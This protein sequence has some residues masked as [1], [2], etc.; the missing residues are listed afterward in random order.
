MIHKNLTPGYDVHNLGSRTTRRS[1]QPMWVHRPIKLLRHMSPRR[2]AKG[3]MG[4]LGLNNARATDSWV[5]L[6]PDP[7]DIT[8]AAV[9]LW[10]FSV[11]RPRSLRTIPCAKL[12]FCLG[13]LPQDL[14]QTSAR[15]CTTWPA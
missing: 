6:E 13:N 15:G 8:S 4:H 11:A 9:L 12:P 5:T 2:K 1:L 7:K 14:V 3:P 10:H